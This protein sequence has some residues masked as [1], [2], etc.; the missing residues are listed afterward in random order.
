[1]IEFKKYNKIAG[2]YKFENKINHKCYIGQSIDI[3]S[4]LR[5][6]ICNFKHR[7]YDA[8]LY[9]AFDKY[10]IESFDV[11]ILYSIEN[12]IPDIKILLD[13]LEIGYIEKY[14]SYGGTG[15]NQT[16]GADAGILGYKFTEEQRKRTSENSRIAAKQYSTR[17]WLYNL[18]SGWTFSFPSIMSAANHFN[19]SHAQITRLCRWKQLTLNKSWIGSLEESVL[20]ER[21][22][23]VKSYTPDY[24][25]H[26]V[27]FRKRPAPGL[28]RH[29]NTSDGKKIIPLE[30]REKIRTSMYKYMIEVYENDKLVKIY[31]TS[32]ELNDDLFKHKDPRYAINNIRSYQKHGWKYRGIYT[33]KLI[34]KKNI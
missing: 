5:H 1:M 31:N 17:V 12:P 32:K 28:K 10:G 26:V 33:F 34:D 6:H 30:Q 3:G 4:R 15:Y 21:A 8:P 20:Q 13:R 23:F 27:K 9:R 25:N 11:E 7:R 29:F 14:N 2:I 16:R 22:E 24:R 18:E 19:C